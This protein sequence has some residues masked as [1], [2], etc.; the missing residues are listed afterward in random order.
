MIGVESLFC[1]L[2]LAVSKKN[3]IFSIAS[4]RAYTESY[5]LIKEEKVAQ[6]FEL[7]QLEQMRNTPLFMLMVREVLQIY[8]F[9]IVYTIKTVVISLIDI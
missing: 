9:L 6:S 2:S 7:V 8:L 4:H 5:T 1:Y 3:M